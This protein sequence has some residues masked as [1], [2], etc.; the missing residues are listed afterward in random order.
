MLA[1]CVTIIITILRVAVEK[2]KNTEQQKNFQRE[3]ERI[4]VTEQRK[5][6]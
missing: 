1:D 2:E 5:I 6:F 3:E 4:Q